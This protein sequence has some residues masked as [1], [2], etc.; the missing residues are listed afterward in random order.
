MGLAEDQNALSLRQRGEWQYFREHIFLPYMETL[1]DDGKS[2]ELL[3]KI[4]KVMHEGERKAWL[5]AEPAAAEPVTD[6]EFE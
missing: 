1:P 6:C 4:M 5:M 2:I 3:G